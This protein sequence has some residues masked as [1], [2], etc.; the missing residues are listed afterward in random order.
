MNKL[1]KFATGAA[2]VAAT[3]FPVIALASPYTISDDV[4]GSVGLGT[5]DLKT[6]VINIIS[7]VLG[8]LAL[9][10]VVMI[11]IGGFQWLTA[12][13]NE[14][15]IEKAKKVISAAV[16][17]LIIVLLAWAIVIFVAGT[18]KNVTT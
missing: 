3:A 5:A 6:T 8:I 18:T 11:I 10:A 9:V 2:L 16:I 12:A 15:K 4:G 13:G 1:A 7:W 14:E 17:G